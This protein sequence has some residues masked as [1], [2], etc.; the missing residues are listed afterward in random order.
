MIG[1]IIQNNY[2]YIGCLSVLYKYSLMSTVIFWVLMLHGLANTGV[3][4]ESFRTLKM[5]ALCSS[6]TLVSS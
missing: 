3:S 2:H 5:Q 1:D 6:K 4:E